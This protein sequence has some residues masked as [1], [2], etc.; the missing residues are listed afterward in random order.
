MSSQ[1][2]STAGQPPSPDQRRRRKRIFEIIAAFASSSIVL[3]F[4]NAVMNGIIGSFASDLAGRFTIWLRALINANLI[5][6]LWLSMAI[7]A[8]E[9]IALIKIYLL[10][11]HHDLQADNQR[12]NMQNDLVQTHTALQTTQDELSQT[13]IALQT[14]Q[15]DLIR[16][17]KEQQIT[18]NELKDIKVQLVERDQELKFDDFMFEILPS[19]IFSGSIDKNTLQKVLSRML[20]QATE[21]AIF[22][23]DVHRAAIF[24]PDDDEYLRMKAHYQMPA[25][26]VLRTV[27]YIGK[28]KN[29][30]DERA[31][32]GEAYLAQ[33]L[34][35]VHFNDE[36]DTR[37]DD[38]PAYKNFD[39]ER[40]RLPYRSL[41]LVPIPAIT[42]DA[43]IGSTQNCYGILC[44]DSKNPAIFDSPKAQLF[45]QLVSKRLA[46][47]LRAHQPVSQPNSTPVLP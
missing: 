30:E 7:I 46:I 24:I 32:V 37:S 4:I 33:Q 38:C 14:T 12:Q 20:H 6:L 8:F 16:K 21:V 3:Y 36:S 25:D 35:V 28:D 5:L 22:N 44:L 34:K 17:E 10:M 41:I 43:S 31:A 15:D 9:F 23:G 29:K 27:G 13:C 42:T 19:S 1:Q 47:V 2:Q 40:T 11:Y 26:S 18:Q 39:K 45:L